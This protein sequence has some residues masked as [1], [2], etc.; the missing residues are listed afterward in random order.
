MTFSTKKST[1]Y[2]VK[3]TQNSGFA[4]SVTKSKDRSA[5]LPSRQFCELS[6]DAD[7]ERVERRYRI[8]H[9]ATAFS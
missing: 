4:S 9:S 7:S 1:Y 5:L 8:T 3:N 6:S 2:S